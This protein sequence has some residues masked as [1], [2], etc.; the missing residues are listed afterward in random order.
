M[1]DVSSKLLD[2][3][4]NIMS[5]LKDFQKATV[6]RIDYL[7][8]HGQ[9]RV[10]VSDE[11]GLGKTLIARGTVAKLAVLQKENADNL[12][13]VVYICS[14]AA[15]AEQNLNKLRITSEL[16][17]EGMNSSRLSMQH[18]NIFKQEHD[19]DLL[20]RYIQLIPLT[21]DT[22]FRIT[23]GAGTVSERALMFAFLK[24]IS[25]LEDYLP[26]LEIA[27]TDWASAAWASHRD[28][29]EKEVVDCNDKSDGAYL[30]YMMEAT[31]KGL[32]EVQSDGMTLLSKVIEMCLSIRENGMK[33]TNNNSAIGR[34]RVL[35]SKISL[36]KLEP[37]L[38]I[39]RKSVV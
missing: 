36:D 30:P 24:R 18:L 39:D 12:V 17:A 32:N 8:R 34:L 38:V 35:F 7:F 14:N 10:L 22:S 6:N 33:R 23:V 3:E 25:A 37:D 4:K 21:P 1:I 28:W 20:S 31:E 15:I 27:M 5:G 16:R 29:Y 26:E 19:T 13:K 2:I 9:K 11:V